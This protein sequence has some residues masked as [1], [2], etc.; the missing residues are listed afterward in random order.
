MMNKLK[1][2]INNLKFKNYKINKILLSRN[3]I[4]NSKN[5]FKILIILAKLHVENYHKLLKLFPILIKKVSKM[6]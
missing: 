4:Y 1:S 6:M 5:S 2:K 3:L